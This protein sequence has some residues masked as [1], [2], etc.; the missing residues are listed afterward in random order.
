METRSTLDSAEAPSTTNETPK[1]RMRFPH[2]TSPSQC[3]K[4]FVL[5][6]NGQPL[7]V[8]AFEYF[9]VIAII[10]L[11]H[12]KNKIIP[13]AKTVGSLYNELV[14]TFNPE[15]SSQRTEKEIAKIVRKYKTKWSRF[16]CISKSSAI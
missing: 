2:N 13:D 9:L 10:R 7:P 14:A 1:K 15:G 12:T 16:N 3:T 8:N 6:C 11:L 5:S 4:K